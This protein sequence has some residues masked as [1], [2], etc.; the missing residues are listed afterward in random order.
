M[1]LD[2]AATQQPPTVTVHGLLQAERALSI[3]SPVRLLSAR[4]AAGVGGCGWWMNLVKAAR[5]THP[6]TPCTDLLDCGDAPGLAMAALR[7]GQRHLVLHPCPAFAAVTA[8]AA[9]LGAVVLPTRP[10][11]LDLDERNADRR[12]GAWLTRDTTRS[13]G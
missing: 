6:R 7:I 2:P 3:G 12:L 8:A 4:G 10:P 13:L 1:N 11:T 5:Q 9:T